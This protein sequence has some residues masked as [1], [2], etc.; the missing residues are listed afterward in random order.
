MQKTP[1]SF[2]LINS[3]YSDAYH[4]YLG[5]VHVRVGNEATEFSDANP[6]V[7][8]GIVDGGIFQ[9]SPIR[10]GQ[11]FTLRRNGA[12]PV[13]N[14]DA[15]YIY[16][17]KVYE[18]PSLFHLYEDRVSVTADT[19][20]SVAKFEPVNL[21]QNLEN[22]SCESGRMALETAQ[23]FGGESAELLDQDSCYKVTQA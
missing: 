19:S 3:C 2:L 12:N 23:E 16:E 22:R 13:L 15:F 7:K 11:F 4:K 1:V 8:T 21:I 9:L 17:I 5:E 6:I 14:D 10:S 20:P 18:C